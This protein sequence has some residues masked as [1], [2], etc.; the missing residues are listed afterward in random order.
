MNLTLKYFT[1][2]LKYIYNSLRQQKRATSTEKN[3][4]QSLKTPRLNSFRFVPGETYFFLSYSPCH[5]LPN[6]IPTLAYSEKTRTHVDL[7]W[8]QKKRVVSDLREILDVREEA[9]PPQRAYLRFWL[10]SLEINSFLC[11]LLNDLTHL[12]STVCCYYFCLFCV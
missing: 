5:I 2:S 7:V 3:T 10:Q 11:V 12:Y 9:G 8:L 6:W 4:Y 1:F